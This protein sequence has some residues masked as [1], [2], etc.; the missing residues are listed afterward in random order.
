[1]TLFG[2]MFGIF[3]EIYHKSWPNVGKYTIDDPSCMDPMGFLAFLSHP[4]VWNSPRFEW[5]FRSSCNVVFRNL[6]SYS[7]HLNKRLLRSSWSWWVGSSL[8]WKF[9]PKISITSGISLTSTSKV[10]SFI[11]LGLGSDF[12]FEHVEIWCASSENSCYMLILVVSQVEWIVAG[13]CPQHQI[14]MKG[15]IHRITAL[16]GVKT[17]TYLFWGVKLCKYILV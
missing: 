10:V 17:S 14:R 8:G 4:P 16:I 6:G 1:M 9:C 3:I 5:V 13:V 7:I 12:F 11:C 2:Y 15:A